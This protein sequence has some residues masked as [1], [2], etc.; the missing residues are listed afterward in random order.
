MTVR[1]R[2][3]AT[4]VAG[5]ALLT[6]AG[7]RRPPATVDPGDA[8]PVR[9]DGQATAQDCPELPSVPAAK[10]GSEGD[11]EPPRILSAQFV[12]GDRI[13]LSFSEALAPPDNINPRQFRIS[14]GYS[15][16][17]SA[18]GYNYATA[19]YEDV[20]GSDNSYQPM[21]VTS[22]Q[23]Y[24][25]RPEV[26][27]L[28]FNQPVPED[29][30][31]DLA[32]MRLEFEEAARDPEGVTERGEVGLFLHYTSRGSVGI[33]DL[34]D[35]PLEDMGPEWALHFG[36]RHKQSYGSEPVAR[37][38]LLVSLECPAGLGSSAPPGPS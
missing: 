13:Q 30:C 14:W 4:G 12:A 23:V 25:G 21:V 18:D 22:L 1:L 33:R 3:L 20:G 7:C 2:D 15:L 6:S 5:C 11:R 24:D 38:D 35:N 27:G 29:L 34:A 37:F 9:G 31:A 17:D 26:L 28:R 19:Y 36:T 16:I 10:P 32:D 8:E